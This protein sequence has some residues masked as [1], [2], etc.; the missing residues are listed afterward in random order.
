MTRKRI[1]QL[2]SKSGDVGVSDYIVAFSDGVTYKVTPS[3]LGAL[4]QGTDG[5]SAYQVA[6]DNGFIGNVS[7]W[8]ISLTGATGTSGTAG[9][10]GADFDYSQVSFSTAIDLSSAKVMPPTTVSGALTFTTTGTPS[11]FK[12][13]Y[14]R[15]IAN[16]TNTP[17][18]SNFVEWGGSLGWVNIA[19]TVNNVTFFYDGT[20]S[21]YSVTQ[22]YAPASGGGGGG[23]E[24]GGGDPSPT[25]FSFNLVSGMV[26]SGD[27]TAGYGYLAS[28]G[29]WAGYAVSDQYS[30]TG[31]G[32][33]QGRMTANGILGF[34]STG[35]GANY[36]GIVTGVYIDGATNNPRVVTSGSAAD[37]NISSS[38]DLSTF[39]LYRLT[40]SGTTITLRASDDD[41]ATWDDVH[42]WTGI[43]ATLY[44]VV[45]GY[46]TG[47]G[48]T[49]ILTE[50]FA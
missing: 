30:M 5:K 22:A 49:E 17:D 26:E 48:A 47:N 25:R 41:G 21:Y 19:D 23:E 12:P 27:S 34:S 50:G 28:V 8:L 1:D 33:L 29:G 6:V 45:N 7:E 20:E 32:F 42:S 40:R 14:V 11:I 15:L 46:D 35:T 43:S 38:F 9:A 2:P 4:L 18:F 37:A 44:P 13:V 10:D 16:G 39:N 3:Q 31:D 24:G 36:S